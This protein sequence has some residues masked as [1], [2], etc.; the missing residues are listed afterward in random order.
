[1]AS[2]GGSA[3]VPTM[4]RALGG[5]GA[6]HPGSILQVPARTPRPR[7]KLGQGRA[8]Q[9]GP[10]GEDDA[11]GADASSSS[12]SP[13]TPRAG[14]PRGA[15]TPCFSQIGPPRDRMSSSHLPGRGQPGSASTG[16]GKRGMGQL[17]S[18]PSITPR[19]NSWLLIY[20]YELFTAWPHCKS[21]IN[22]CSFVL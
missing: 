18:T 3:H 2:P 6:S 1:M 15:L 7:T 17:L 14:T 9:K 10:W 4:C 22:R 13:L 12:A 16:T 8:R 11:D 20:F 5:F 21:M 19:V